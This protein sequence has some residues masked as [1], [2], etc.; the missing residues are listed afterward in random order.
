MKKLIYTSV[1]VSL[2]LSGSTQAEFTE[3]YLDTDSISRIL[4]DL[5]FFKNYGNRLKMIDY[6]NMMFKF[7]EL[8]T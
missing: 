7:S 5:D 8:Q 3:L 6:E 4:S 2:L 1:L